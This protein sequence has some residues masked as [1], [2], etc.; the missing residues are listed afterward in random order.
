MAIGHM[1]EKK[2]IRENQHAGFRITLFRVGKG[3][4]AH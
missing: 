1:P 4:E 3:Q 2:E